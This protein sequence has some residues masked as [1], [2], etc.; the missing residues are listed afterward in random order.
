MRR[1]I[2]LAIATGYADSVPDFYRKA[3][4]SK[5]YRD[6]GL[7]EFEK[8]TPKPFFLISCLGFKKKVRNYR[9]TSLIVR[10]TGYHLE[11]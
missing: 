1:A 3:I 5:L 4:A 9:E 11:T 8:E 7:L 6:E 2:A 10:C